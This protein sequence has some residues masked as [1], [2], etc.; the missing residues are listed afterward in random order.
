MTLLRQDD[1]HPITY[2]ES[3]RVKVGGGVVVLGGLKRK[4][5]EG[6]EM[7]VMMPSHGEPPRFDQGGV[8]PSARAPMDHR[9]ND[10]GVSAEDPAAAAAAA[11][12]EK[13]RRMGA[14][15]RYSEL[16]SA[17]EDYRTGLLPLIV[18]VALV[19]FQVRAHD[20][21]YLMGQLYFDPHPKELMLRNH[22]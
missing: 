4:H 10:G 20:V 13:E 3:M 7:M 11:A 16:Q 17:I 18:P 1:S 6:G 14:K 5:P 2:E 12:V 9:L 19:R 22:A 21:E 15:R 8:A